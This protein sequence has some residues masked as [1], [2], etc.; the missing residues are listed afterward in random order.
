MDKK[1]KTSINWW[2][3]LKDTA[4]SLTKT[5]LVRFTL[6]KILGSAVAGGF[7]GWIITFLVEEGFE[8]IVQPIMQSA[9]RKIGYTYSVI[10]G[11]HTLKEIENAEDHEDWRDAIG[12]A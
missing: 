11:K 5:Q 9:F 7:Y 4:I 12:D 10:N 1:G 2:Q 6:R 8:N 3:V